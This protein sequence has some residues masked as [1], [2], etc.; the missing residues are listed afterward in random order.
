MLDSNPSEIHK[1]LIDQIID[2]LKRDETLKEKIVEELK[3][4]NLTTLKFYTTPTL[5]KVGN[6]E[7]PVISLRN[8]PTSKTSDFVDFQIQPVVTEILSY[9]QDTKDF[10]NKLKNISNVPEKRYLI[11]MDVKSLYNSILNFVRIAA[12]KKP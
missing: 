3:I 2:W 8:S 4:A 10:L 9:A 11:T 6:L 1:K 5:H 7:R 12:S